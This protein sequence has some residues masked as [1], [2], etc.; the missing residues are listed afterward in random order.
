MKRLS[1]T[2]ALALPFLI[3]PGCDVQPSPD[4]PRAAVDADPTPECAGDCDHGDADG[5][6]AGH[7]P[8]HPSVAAPTALAASVLANVERRDRPS[9][10]GPDPKVQIMVFSDFQCPYCAKI[11]PKLEEALQT[12]GDDVSLTFKQMPL[13][14]H[15]SAEPAARASLAAHAQ[16]KFWPMHDRMFEHPDLVKAGDFVAMAGE[17]GLDVAR[18]ERDMDDPAIAAQVRQDAEDAAALGIRGTPSLVIGDQLVVGAQP[19]SVIL[20]A[21]DAELAGA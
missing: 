4:E 19:I 21:I 6:A 20:A 15:E 8:M 16:G 3:L 10:G 9:T 13:P 14:F 12:Y 2:C 1:W 7:G 18:F 11:V 5:G 17:L